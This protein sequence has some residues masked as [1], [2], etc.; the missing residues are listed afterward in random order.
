MKEYQEK[1][2]V[3]EFFAA[4]SVVLVLFFVMIGVGLAS[5]RALVRGW[6]VQEERQ[7]ME[8][9]L[10]D[11]KSQKEAISSEVE[12]F[13]SGRGIEY[14][15]REKLNLRKPGEEVVIITENLTEAPPA[16]ENSILKGKFFSRLLDIFR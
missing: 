1:R 11:L 14:E 10:I 5:F 3:R 8:Q 7:A 2:H 15:A 16:Q 9:R 12:D 6:E 4:R 13:K